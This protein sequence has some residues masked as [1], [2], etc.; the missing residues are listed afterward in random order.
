MGALQVY[1]NYT[2]LAAT[3]LYS[4][5]EDLAKFVRSQIPARTLNKG[6]LNK[7]TL[8]KSGPRILSDES[9]FA[10][11]QELGKVEGMA[12]WGAGVMLY[13]D[14]TQGGYIVGHGGRSP[15]LNAS[16]RMN[17]H[18]GNAFIMVQTGNQRAFASAMATHWTN[19]ETGTPDIFQ[20]QRNIPAMIKTIIIGAIII[21]FLS[22]I[23]T[24]LL[25]RYKRRG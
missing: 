5:T 1:P 11:H 6:T 19:W 12:I 16:A 23:G 10:M 18:T 13:A 15:M 9:I 7:G 21:G 20:L 2:S 17:P 14:N 8:N 4:T 24:L 25:I 22:L 3:G